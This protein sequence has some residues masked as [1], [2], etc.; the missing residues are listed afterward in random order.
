MIDYVVINEKMIEKIKR[1]RIDRMDS[2][3]IGDDTE[4]RKKE[5]KKRRRRSI[6]RRKK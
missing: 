4:E 5:D 3:T 2:S 6:R 1:F